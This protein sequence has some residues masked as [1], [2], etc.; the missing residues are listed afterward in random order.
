MLKVVNKF[1]DKDGTVYEIGDEYKGDAD[2][3]RLHL[4]STKENK[5]KTVFLVE[6]DNEPENNS[7]EVDAKETYPVHTGGGYY[8]LSNGEKVQGKDKAEAA[9]KALQE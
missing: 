3:E 2:E 8:T 6:E 4:L 9:E 1:K 5:Y 7:P